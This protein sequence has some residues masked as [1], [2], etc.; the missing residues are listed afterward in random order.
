MKQKG[1]NNAT[2]IH[3]TCIIQPLLHTAEVL[4]RAES[5]TGSDA[6]MLGSWELTPAEQ[7]P[8]VPEKRCPETDGSHPGGKMR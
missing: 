1:G 3:H 6:V 8:P 5:R 7:P 2:R 4:R